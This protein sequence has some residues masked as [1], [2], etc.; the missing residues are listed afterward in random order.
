MI[1][2]VQ[3]NYTCRRSTCSTK[4]FSRKFSPKRRTFWSL[5]MLGGSTFR[6]LMSFRWSKS[7][8]WRRKTSKSRCTSQTSCLKDAYQTENISSIFWTLSSQYTWIRLFG[9][10]M[11]SETPFR[12]R[13]K[14]KKQSKFLTS[15]GMPWP[16]VR[17][18]PVS[19]SASLNQLIFF[20]PMCRAKGKNNPPAEAKLQARAVRSKAPQDWDQRHLP[21]VQANAGRGKTG[22][23]WGGSRSR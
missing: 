8:R 9:M 1:T 16:R 10:R 6:F 21:A 3:C 2:P 17:S 14:P 20:S 11:I 15:G 12:V 4:I 22:R 5:Q 13:P 19:A 23:G 18:F 7:G